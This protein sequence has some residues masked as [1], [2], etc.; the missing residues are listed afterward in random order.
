MLVIKIKCISKQ[1]IP[2]FKLQS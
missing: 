1:D 2:G